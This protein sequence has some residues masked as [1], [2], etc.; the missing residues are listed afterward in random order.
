MVPRGAGTSLAGGALPTADSVIL[1]IAR[2]NRV[3]EVDYDNRVI[4]VEAGRTNLS[5]T[6]AVRGGRLLLRARSL[7]AA[8]L[9]HRRQYRDEFGRRALPEI[10]G[11]D[12]QPPR[13]HDGDDGRHRRR[14]WRRAS[15]RAGLRFPGPDLR[16][17]GPARRRDRGDAA[18]PA[19]ARR[20]APGPRSPSAR[21]RSRAPASRTSSRRASC[22][23]PSSSWTGPASAPARISPMPVIPIARRC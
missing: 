14:A 8:R 21:T 16:L 23:W 2:M 3:L 1:G 6:G 7:L 9:R 18:H 20:R 11:H 12:Q 19:Q 17:G 15:R 13:R 4:R 5:V 10:R 22:R